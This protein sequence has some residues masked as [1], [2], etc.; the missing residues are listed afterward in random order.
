MTTTDRASNGLPPHAE[1]HHAT[2]HACYP[3]FDSGLAPNRP[4]W[5]ADL[6]KR[7]TKITNTKLF[8]P[9][10][11]C[12]V[13]YHDPGNPQPRNASKI[14]HLMSTPAGSQIHR[15]ANIQHIPAGATHKVHR[16]TARQTMPVDKRHLRKLRGQNG[17]QINRRWRGCKH[18]PSCGLRPAA[19]LRLRIRA[20]H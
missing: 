9:R 16:S 12:H 20:G 8:N 14:R 7:W 1:A 19:I 10:T 13:L 5:Q 11:L 2:E 6:I 3:L 18:A 15:Q 4:L 17:R